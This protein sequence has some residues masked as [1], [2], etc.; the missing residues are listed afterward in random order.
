V[1]SPAQLAQQAYEQLAPPAPVVDYR[2]RHH[3]GGPE[4]TLVGLKTFLWVAPAS[5]Q[6]ARRRAA[7]GVNWA[8]VTATVTSVAFDPGDGSSPVVCPAGGTPYDPALPYAAQTADCWHTYTRPSAAGPFPLR[9]TVTWAATWTG[10]GG[11][12]GVLPAVTATTTVPV[13]VQEMQVVNH[14]APGGWR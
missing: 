13:Q 2:P 10:S 9:A 8:E 11:A 6:P 5:L 7:A 14:A 12:G 1:P 3:P 4:A